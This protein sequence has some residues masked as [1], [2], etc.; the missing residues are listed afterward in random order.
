MT[1]YDDDPNLYGN[2]DAGFDALFTR[3][4]AVKSIGAK[5]GRIIINGEPLG[6]YN[7]AEE[8]EILYQAFYNWI[9]SDEFARSSDLSKRNYNRA[10][11]KFVQFL[12]QHTIT[13]QNRLSVIKSFESFRVNKEGVK[14]Q[15]TLVKEIKTILNSRS[16]KKGLSPDALKYLRFLLRSTTVSISEERESHTLTGWFES[17]PW[18][19]R[20]MRKQDYSSL[21]SP[22]RLTD[23][24][25]TI[26][27]KTL[28]IIK[29]AKDQ[30]AK[31]G[32]PDYHIY[33]RIDYQMSLQHGRFALY[34]N[35][36][37]RFQFYCSN[38]LDSVSGSS[39]QLMIIDFVTDRA[40]EMATKWTQ[41]TIEHGER[42]NVAIGNVKKPFIKPTIFYPGWD[43]SVSNSEAL[44]FSWLCST[45]MIQPSDIPRLKKRDFSII[46][47]DRGRPMYIQCTYYKSRAQR[48]HESPIVDARSAT[49]QALLQYLSYFNESKNHHSL[50]PRK[51]FC[52]KKFC[53]IELKGLFRPIIGIWT[54]GFFRDELNS[55]VKDHKSSSLFLRAMNV[56]VEH[57]GRS[58]K[59]Y[60]E[61]ISEYRNN[62]TNPLPLDWF[63]GGAIKTSSVHARSDKYRDNDPLNYNSH[64][65]ET[66]KQDYLTDDNKDYVNR[67]GRIIRQVM[68]E[69]EQYQYKPC[70]YAAAE[71]AQLMSDRTL[72]SSSDQ[73][74]TNEDDDGFAADGD[75][76][77]V[78]DTEDT[79]VWMLHYIEQAESKQKSLINNNIEF[80][81]K[82]VLPTCEWME[83][84]MNER[85]SPKIV[86]SGTK[87]YN[88]L[89]SELGPLFLNELSG[90]VGV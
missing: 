37:N 49:G 25:S 29:D 44:L 88:E 60:E 65:P 36:Y 42:P 5:P 90:G 6:L 18:L 47:N 55:F 15:S 16:S 82:T 76:L 66:E 58:K 61:T 12:S 46:K 64:S 33:E 71:E 11:V 68:L 63:A 84:V 67:H 35:E 73:T 70:L 81:E 3:P 8:A 32:I 72:V 78:L 10:I 22:K 31:E 59:P 27:A 50:F 80:F 74:N 21:E 51:V 41:R 2:D 40:R 77:I 43:N 53:T 57:G 87:R 9:T 45:L 62:V 54:S 56:V 28:L 34:D 26:V 52:R 20:Y 38:L 19:K 89:R 79:V 13:T 75:L 24:F 39:R 23:S 14:P 83:V 86:Q 30:A 17:M 69:I 1:I 85:M 4:N 48:I 7:E